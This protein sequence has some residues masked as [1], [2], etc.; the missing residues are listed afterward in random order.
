MRDEGVITKIISHGLAEVALKKNDACAKCGVCHEMGEGMVGIEAANELGAKPGD[1]VELEVQSE[2]I[3]KGSMVLFLMPI[4]FLVAGYLIGSAIV[5]SFGFGIAEETA[6][7]VLGI[8]ALIIS[9]LF[10]NWYDKSIR[11][12]SSLRARIVKIV[13]PV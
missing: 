11:E 6:G 7:I 1:I 10:V 3:I 9:F 12:K 8:T 4:F 5:R 13:A 2:E